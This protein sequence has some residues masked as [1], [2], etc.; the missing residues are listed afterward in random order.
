ME[1]TGDPEGQKPKKDYVVGFS[2]TRSSHLIPTL[3]T[4]YKDSNR[5]EASSSLFTPRQHEVLL[6]NIFLPSVRNVLTEICVNP[7]QFAHPLSVE[8]IGNFVSTTI[9]ASDF[10]CRSNLKGSME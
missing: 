9:D 8:D 7:R 1:A 10:T 4:R 6:D 3:A 5:G 2:S